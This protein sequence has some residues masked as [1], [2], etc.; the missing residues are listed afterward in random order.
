MHNS[1]SIELDIVGAGAFSL[2]P[3]LLDFKD[4]LRARLEASN[5][6]HPVIDYDHLFMVC[7][8]RGQD[9]WVTDIVPAWRLGSTAAFERSLMS[10]GMRAAKTIPWIVAFGYAFGI[11][12]HS[13]AGGHAARR[14]DAGVISGLNM[15]LLALLDRLIDEHP[16]EFAL[17][18]D[19][20]TRESIR[21][22]VVNRTPPKRLLRDDSPVAAGL[23]EL[24]RIYLEFGYGMLDRS[25]DKAAVQDVWLEALLQAHQAESVSMDRKMSACMPTPEMVVDCAQPSV[26]GAWAIAVSSCLAE[27]VSDIF[28]VRPFAE[29]YGSLTWKV[30]DVADVQKDVSNDIWNGFCASVALA[31]AAGLERESVFSDYEARSAEEVRELYR[32]LSRFRWVE[33]DSFSMADVLWAYLWTWLGGQAS[34]FDLGQ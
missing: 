32:M 26:S 14:H 11:A 20:F 23:I 15:L 33:R 18:K 6:Q 4:R 12:C 16:Q 22:W 21:D 13:L 10:V 34:W 2:S 7:P 1:V 5:A 27:P 19:C 9:V 30:D 17:V 31:E 3:E 24:Y 8:Q 28:S 29:L 25:P